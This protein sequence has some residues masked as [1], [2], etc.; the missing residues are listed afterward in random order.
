MMGGWVSGWGGLREGWTKRNKNRRGKKKRQ[1]G[2]DKKT[3]EEMSGEGAALI[4]LIVSCSMLPRMI[5]FCRLHTH[6]SQLGVFDLADTERERERRGR[7][8]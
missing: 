5:G 6:L 8:V 7:G 3:E 4:I 1:N 2:S